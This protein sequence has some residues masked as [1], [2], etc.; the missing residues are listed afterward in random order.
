MPEIEKQLIQHFRSSKG[1]LKTPEIQRHRL[2]GFIS[3][4]VFLGTTTNTW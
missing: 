4:G 1:G 3:A 2:E